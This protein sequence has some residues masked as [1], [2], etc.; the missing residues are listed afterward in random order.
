MGGTLMT[1][2]RE[3]FSILF[4]ALLEREFPEEVRTRFNI[5]PEIGDPKKPYVILLPSTGLVFD[6]KF[7]KEGRGN[8]TLWVEDLRDAPPIPRDI[9]VNQ[10]IV[11]T[12]ETIRYCHLFRLLVRH[13]KPVL[14]VG[15]TGTGKSVYIMDFLLKKNEPKVFMPLFVIFSAQTTANMT[16]DI[17]MSKLERRKKGSSAIKPL[18]LI[19]DLISQIDSTLLSFVIGLR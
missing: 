11:C 19:I 6:Y 15:P 9:P 2:Y 3:W 16:Q 14:V 17:I 18:I 12:V 13:H 10:I 4:R 1:S 5:S 8:W 7:I